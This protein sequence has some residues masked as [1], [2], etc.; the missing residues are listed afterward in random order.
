[1][2]QELRIGLL[3]FG[4]MGKTHAFCVNNLRY[5]YSDLPFRAAIRG[6]CT[7][8]E[9]KSRRVAEKFDIPV[10]CTDEDVLLH[11]PEV[12]IVDICTP[13]RYHYETI[14]KA[15]AA[16]KHVYCEKPLCVTASQ[17]REVAE[18]AKASGKICTV[19]FNNRHLAPVM[20][21]A[22]LIREGRIG[23]ILSFSA[24]YLHNSCTDV[25]RPAGWKQ[26]RDI[27]GGGV[28]FDLGS[29]VIDLIYFLC[30]EF[31]AVY[32]MPQIGYPR[33]KGM[34]G[35]EWET[36]ADEGFHML[37]RLKSGAMGSITVSKLIHGANDDLSFAVYGEKGSLKFS[38]MQPNFLYFYDAT[39]KPSALGGNCGYQAIE[40]VGRYPAP[41]GSFPAPKAPSGWI[42]GHV[43]SMYQF[44]NSVYLEKQA[45]PDFA[46]GAHVQLVM[47]AAYLS[48]EQRGEIHLSQLAAPREEKP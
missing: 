45:A 6:V 3:G 15:L 34:K 10:A 7:T 46:D 24:E 2:K 39:E 20:R 28:L 36:N 16:G 38:L 23:R 31:E 17:A 1:M 29:H 32:G 26:N 9:E 42:R 8:S 13:N 14:K 22:E 37:C 19:V 44:L 5:Y 43:E 27:C 21:A 47:E 12:D 33:R 40:C 35:E 48:A 11:D 4:A 18:L 41:G 30:G 25:L